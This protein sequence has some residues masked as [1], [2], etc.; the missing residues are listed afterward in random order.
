MRK[1]FLV[2]GQTF[3]FMQHKGEIIEKAV[4]QSGYSITKLAKKLGKSTRW[5]YYMFESSN[6]SIDY[7]IEIG[8]IL[9]YDFSNEIKELKRYRALHE[10]QAIKES[11]TTYKP[12]QEESE[13]W[14]N[15]YL[16]LLEKHNQLLQRFST[17]GNQIPQ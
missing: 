4:R 2:F 17:E 16:A 8:E 9:H 12:E 11:E 15:K 13:Y 7:I 10:V 1:I 6:V 3:V 14:K 5:M